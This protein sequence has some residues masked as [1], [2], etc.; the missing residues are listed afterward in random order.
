MA[1][2]PHHMVDL[3]EDRSP[4]GLLL[5]QEVALSLQIITCFSHLCATH[6]SALGHP[7]CPSLAP[8]LLQPCSHLLRIAFFLEILEMVSSLTNSEHFGDAIGT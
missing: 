1:T 7:S 2:S 5:E 4:W 6:N 3:K 8:A